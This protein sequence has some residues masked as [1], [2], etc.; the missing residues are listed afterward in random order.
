LPRLAGRNLRAMVSKR[1]RRRDL[2]G[3]R[4]H[5]D[6]GCA[7]AQRGNGALVSS[8]RRGVRAKSRWVGLPQA[9]SPGSSAGWPSRAR[10]KTT[11]RTRGELRE[12]SSGAH[13]RAGPKRAGLLDSG[14]AEER[15]ANAGERRPRL[16]THAA[17]RHPPRSRY[18]SHEPGARG[19]CGDG[20]ALREAQADGGR[21]SGPHHPDAGARRCGSA[22]S[23]PRRDVADI[24]RRG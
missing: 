1:E 22:V 23:A 13:A 12:K 24:V 2:P 16:R 20:P 8:Q 10:S 18:A 19:V 11:R 14:V 7:K 5:G 4:G 6:R 21:T 15:S 17:H 3:M 9:A